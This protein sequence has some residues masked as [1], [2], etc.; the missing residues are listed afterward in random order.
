MRKYL[1]GSSRGLIF[2]GIAIGENAKQYDRVEF[3]KHNASHPCTGQNDGCA[4]QWRSAVAQDDNPARNRPIA[5]VTLKA[6]T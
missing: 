4:Q 5:I 2:Q 1:S 3:T 6:Q